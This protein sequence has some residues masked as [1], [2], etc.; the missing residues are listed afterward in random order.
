[1][2]LIAVVAGLAGCVD[3]AQ[4]DVVEQETGSTCSPYFCGNGNSSIVDNMG[5]HD[6]NV[7]GLVNS[8]GFRLT[9]FQK[10]AISYQAKVYASQ[11]VGL[12]A[13]GQVALSGLG[14]QNAELI[15]T[16]TNTNGL[17]YR[18]RIKSVAESEYWA[19]YDGKIQYATTYELEWASSVMTQ[20]QNV[21]VSPP[22]AGHPDL[23]GGQP[24]FS[25]VLFEGDRIDEA[26]KA[27]SPTIDDG[28]FN[29]GCMGHAL[30]KLHLTGHTE[31]AMRQRK[32]PSVVTERETF[33]RMVVGDYCRI[34]KPFTIAGQPLDYKNSSKTLQYIAVTP[35]SLE[36]RWDEGG[37][38]CLDTARLDANPSDAAKAQ[39][40]DGVLAAMLATEK[41]VL[42]PPCAASVESF[43]GH[44]LNSA[45]PQ[46]P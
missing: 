45:N 12:D 10:G 44:Y 33:L 23:R 39:F 26:T 13:A 34:G 28:W 5:L 30:A 27:F 8:T 7:N 15:V 42:P 35:L 38:T 24:A 46:L 11:L 19:K 29:I 25:A 40:P 2:K 22:P 6:L 17:E 3:P 9:G 43:D 18:I 21:C 1:M 31:A 41:C 4:F 20:Y 37:A 32:F 16:N 36:A 14:L